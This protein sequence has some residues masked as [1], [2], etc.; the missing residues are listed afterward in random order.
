D[1]EDVYERIVRPAPAK[2]SKV[3][4]LR[5][6]AAA[7]AVL[8]LAAAAFWLWSAG[9][10]QNAATYMGSHVPPAGDITPG[11]HKAILTLA[12]GSSVT[13]DSAGTQVIRQGKTA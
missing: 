12:D 11:L 13:L 2:R 1:Y 4:T 9:D 7:A 6:M 3:F 8:L 5:R 10:R